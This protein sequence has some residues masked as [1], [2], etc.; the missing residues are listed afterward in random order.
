MADEGNAMLTEQEAAVYDRQIRVWG[1]EAQKRMSKSNILVGGAITGII[2]EALKNIVLAGVGSVT[3]V[4]DTP[5]SAES[6]A[7]TFILTPDLID[8]GVSMGAACAAALQDFNPMVAVRSE[9]GNIVDKAP[10]FYDFFSVVLLGRAP[11]DLQK[12][13]NGICRSRGHKVAFFSAD[14]RGGI[15]QIFV[16]L[17]THNYTPFPKPDT[18][19]EPQTAQYPSLEE[20]LSFSWKP[21]LEQ[22]RK[23]RTDSLFFTMRVLE[24]FEQAEKRRPGAVSAADLP[25]LLKTRDDMAKSQDVLPEMIPDELLERLAD[26]GPGELPA[27][28]AIVGGIL[29][30]EI[31]KS[32]SS[33]GAPVENFFLYSLTKHTGLIERVPPLKKS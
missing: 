24:R 11:L 30:Q 6:I 17:Q 14:V 29:G 27:V 23:E 21:L 16:D 31:L 8:S 19:P 18:T 15:G 9:E 33:K 25:G 10:D 3:L 5:V 1:V 32:V 26:A 13:I 7:A 20:A 22:K 2:A 28:S 4:D 12:K